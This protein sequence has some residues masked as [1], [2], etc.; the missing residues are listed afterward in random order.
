[1]PM[2]KRAIEPS[3]ISQRQLDTEV[4]NELECVANNTLA[5]IIQQLSSLSK[6]SEDLFGELYAET[7]TLAARTS[8]LCTRIEKLKHKIVQLNPTVEE[9]KSFVL[10]IMIMIHFHAA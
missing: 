8:N 4:K 10:M 5:C 9:G 3:D 7:Y 1:M 2:V 6:H